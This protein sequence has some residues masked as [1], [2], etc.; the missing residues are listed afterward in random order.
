[1]V[2]TVFNLFFLPIFRFNVISELIIKKLSKFGHFINY[3]KFFFLNVT[4]TFRDWIKYFRNWIKRLLFIFF[5]I[6]FSLR[7]T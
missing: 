2:F 6:K 3:L 1:M 5:F 7:L 4:Y